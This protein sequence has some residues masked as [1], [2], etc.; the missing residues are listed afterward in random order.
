MTIVD[1]GAEI[2]TITENGYGKRTDIAEY[3]EQGRGGKG[4]KA[5]VFNELTGGLVAFMTVDE[6]QDVIMITDNGTIIRTPVT[7]IRKIGRVTKGVRI[8]KLANGAKIVSVAVVEHEEPEET[9][10][11]NEDVPSEVDVIAE[12]GVSEV[13]SN[14]ETKED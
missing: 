11:N 14:E 5:G 8:M 3:R 12:H 7:D 1:E 6:T 4:T 13:P 9:S 2:L 10:E